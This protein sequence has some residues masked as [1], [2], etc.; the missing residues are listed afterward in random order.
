MHSILPF[1][2]AMIVVILL[3]E[4]LAAKLRIAYPILLV[5]AGL[6]ISFIPGLPV[7]KIDPDLIFFIFLPP[8]LFEAAWS[9]SFKE[10][11]KWWRIIGSFAFLVVFFTA[12]S[13]AFIT[14]YFVPGFTIALGFLLGGIVSPP[15][16]VSTGAITKF[17]KIPNSTSTILEGESLLNDASSLIIFRF[18]LVAVGTGQFIWQEATM[19]FLWM[20]IGGAGIGLLLGWL[21][22]QAHKRLP[23]DAPSDIILTLIEPY[24]M[25]WIAEKV[26]SSG[27]LAVVAGGL[28]M[29]TRRL[30]FLNSTSRV[31]GFSVW[32]SFVFILNGIVFFIIGLQLPEVVSGLRSEGISLNTA[33]GYGVLVTGVLIASRMISS[34]AA[35]IATMI[36]RPGVVPHARSNRRRFL[37]PLLLGWTGMRGVV[38]LAAALAIPITLNGEAFP[39]R[40]LILFITF[41]VILLTLVVQ[42]LTLPYI[43]GR[44]KLFDAFSEEPEKEVKRKLNDGLR[45]H[46]Y[47]FLKNKYDNELHDHAGLQRM[48]KH[49]EEKMEA[50]D[51]DWMNEKTKLIF[52]EMLDSQRNYLSELNKDPSINEEFIRQ[53]LFRIDLEEERLKMI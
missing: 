17:V 8:L 26:H 22:V 9:I 45:K 44:S 7:V 41:V 50:D 30:L 10:M 53:Q 6:M 4:M 24:F 38:S 36:F 43:I 48:L 34:Y 40:N 33:I 29:S 47:Q 39:H 42:G 20:V 46:S 25:Y 23:T 5:I 18:A 1:L 28:F 19:S 31:R 11:K 51:D 52:I 35:M 15:D 32:E 14:N 16:A 12:F 49:W 21:F 27:V 2:L 13:V 37:M 3:L